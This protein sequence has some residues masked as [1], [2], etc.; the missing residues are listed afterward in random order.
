MDNS[1]KNILLIGGL[2]AV[3]YYLWSKGRSTLNSAENTLACWWANLTM[4]PSVQSQLQ[5]NVI[6]P[7]GSS[8]STS[9]L[10]DMC[11]QQDG[12]TGL[13]TFE[14]GGQTYQLGSQICGNYPACPL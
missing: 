12:V 3:A 7:C 14:Y 10:Q 8:F 13:T 9:Q 4:G 11:L 6:M 5:G 2:A 1:T